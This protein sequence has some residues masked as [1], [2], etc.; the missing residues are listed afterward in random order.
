MY[1]NAYT[2]NVRCFSYT[3][4]GGVNVIVHNFYKIIFV[5]KKLFQ[6]NKL[7][8]KKH[9]KNN[10][11]ILKNMGN[12]ISSHIKSWTSTFSPRKPLVTFLSTFCFAIF[13]SGKVFCFLME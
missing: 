6:E 3:P 5:T 4:T 9:F 10:Y 2:S 11:F 8:I 1:G 12:V 7:V 13:F